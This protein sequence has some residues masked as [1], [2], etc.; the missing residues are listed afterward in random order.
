MSKILK[1]ILDIILFI[2]RLIMDSIASLFKLIILLV[3]IV[4]AVLY[5]GKYSIK[6]F[7]SPTE[8][9]ITVEPTKSE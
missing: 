7:F 1:F 8:K 4:A 2:P 5:F 9:A 6:S 3:I